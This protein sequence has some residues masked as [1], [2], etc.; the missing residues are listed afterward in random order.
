M[1]NGNDLELLSAYLD[2][3]LS[4]EERATLEARLQNDAELRRELDRLRATVALIKT[5][6]T[7]SAPRPLTLTPR[8]VHR[9]NI[10]T[11]AAFSALSAAAAVVLLV[12][13]AALFTTTRPSAAPAQSAARNI[14]AVPTL[15]VSVNEPQA[16]GAN[17]AVSPPV[18]DNFQITMEKST[19]ELGQD[20]SGVLGFAGPTETSQPSIEA[21]LYAVPQP[22]GTSADEGE[23]QADASVA[24][25]QAVSPLPDDQLRTQSEQAAPSS[26]M[27]GAAAAALA[28]TSA[29]ST[30]TAVPTD[31]DTATVTASDTAT[32][33]S[34]ATL[35]TT[36]VPT[37]STLP[38]LT[39]TSNLPESRAAENNTA[40]VSL[41]ALAL[42]LFC[43]AIVTTILRRRS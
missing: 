22:L 14:A 17:N 38:T 19:G 20:S 21:Q 28:P 12:I 37:A 25:S 26:A 1:L 7:L 11:S 43:I 15:T 30:V 3:A 42:V 4:T 41:I 13:G 8:M 18:A 39:P 31:T 34:S 32:S 10:L 2:D 27:D 6:P 16:G 40:A 23:L 29:P 36:P 9:P 24:Q 33:N 5:L 35:T